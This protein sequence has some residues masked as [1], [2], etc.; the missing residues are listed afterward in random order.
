MQNYVDAV[1]AAGMKGKEVILMVNKDDSL[2]LRVAREIAQMLTDSGLIVQLKEVG[3]HEYHE[4]LIYRTYDLYL[5]QTRLSANMDLTPFLYVWGEIS[6]GHMEDSNLYALCLDALANSGNYL[7]L[8]QK[9]MNDGRLCPILFCGY[10]VYATRGLLSDLV[11]AR[12]NVFWYST[13]KTLED[14]LME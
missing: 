4:S 12:D 7:N 1:N 3:S 2:R 9:V 5:G 6:Y 13:G 14:A 11:P 10:A 8:H